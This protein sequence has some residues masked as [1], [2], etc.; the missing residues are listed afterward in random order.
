MAKGLFFLLVLISTSGIA[1]GLTRK[2]RVWQFPTLFSGAFLFSFVP[3]MANHVFYAGRLPTIVYE[4]YGVELGLLMS[5]LC[6]VA[7]LAGYRTR[8]ALRQDRR[9]PVDMIHL[10]RL[11][12]VGCVLAAI[13][14]FS[15]TRLA[16]QAGGFRAQF[17]EGGHYELS[18]TGVTVMYTYLNRFILVGGIMCV[19]SALRAPRLH[20]WIVAAL[21]FIYPVVVVIFMGRRGLASTIIIGLGTILWFAK[22]WAPPRWAVVIGMAVAGMGVI[23]MPL[24]RTH[25]NRTGNIKEA[26]Q[27]VDVKQGIEHY[28]RGEQAEGMDNLVIGIPARLHSQEFDY[29]LGVGFWNSMMEGLVPAF[30]VSR[31][32]KQ[33]LKIQQGRSDNEIFGEYCGTEPLRG[34]FRTGPYT[35]F[36]QFGFI[37]ALLF[38]LIGRFYRKLWDAAR[39]E[40]SDKAIIMYSLFSIYSTTIVIN[41]LTAIWPDF[42]FN[43]AVISIALYSFRRTAAGRATPR[44]GPL[45][46]AFCDS[47]I[48]RTPRRGGVGFRGHM[49]M[50]SPCR[51]QGLP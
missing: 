3:Q 23:L 2:D 12:R 48:P 18:W 5:L 43:W 6:L 49:Q 39:S 37:G 8:P 17:M 26:L 9:R 30:L 28:G 44:G 21:I 47:G 24:Y 20:R 41:S 4:D 50:P 33:G 16:S 42:L 15:A 38:F 14:L 27:G 10:D 13:G 45:E 22:Q 34:S 25:A 7:G 36:V 31:D 32:I 11:F 1:W 29:Q 46:S 19:F 51:W 35:A 40:K